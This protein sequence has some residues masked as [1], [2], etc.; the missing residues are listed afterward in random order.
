MLQQYNKPRMR[1]HPNSPFG[2]AWYAHYAAMG[3]ASKSYDEQQAEYIRFS[4]T[5]N[6][7]LIPQPPRS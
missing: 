5:W 2:K 1:F 4:M 3:L 7:S 6:R